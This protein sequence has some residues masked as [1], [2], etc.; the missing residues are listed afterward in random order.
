MCQSIPVAMWPK[1]YVC[2]CSI[3][4]IEGLNPTE[5]M[6][7]SMLCLLCGVG[8]GLCNGWITRSQESYWVCVSNCM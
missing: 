7:V 1:V 5:G 8:S 3:A 4:G 6:E 2:S